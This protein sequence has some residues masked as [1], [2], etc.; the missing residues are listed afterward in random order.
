MSLFGSSGIRGV[1]GQ[2]FT[3]DLTVSIS[4]AV[5]SLHQSIVLGRDTRTTGPMEREFREEVG[6][7]FVPVACCR[8]ADG[9]AIFAGEL[10]GPAPP[11]EM[12]WRG[13]RELPEQLSF[14]LVEYLPLIAWARETMID[15]IGRSSD[16][17]SAIVRQC[18]GG[19]LLPDS[20]PFPTT[21]GS[22]TSSSPG[23]T[24]RP[25]Y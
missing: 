24:S 12:E 23:R 21:E 10:G 19:S 20:S 5:G 4:E 9:V 3:V 6:Y 22:R 1:V 25:L 14:P 2:D 7:E 15:N 16:R 8:D 13:F 11:A 18:L 17:F